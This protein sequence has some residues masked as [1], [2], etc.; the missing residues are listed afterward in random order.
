MSTDKKVLM[1]YMC[2]LSLKKKLDAYCEK[3]GQTKSEVIRRAIKK[4]IQVGTGL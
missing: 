2:P 1:T 4:A 3:K